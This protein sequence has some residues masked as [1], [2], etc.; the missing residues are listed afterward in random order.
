MSFSSKKM[1]LKE[2]E[3]GSNL[4]GF[5]ERL[6]Q[7]ENLTRKESEECMDIV[8]KGRADSNQVAALLVLLRAKGET[9]EEVEGIVRT[10]R[11]HMTQVSTSMTDSLLDI[12][13]TGG[14]GA[15]TVNLSTT[16]A[17]LAAACGARVA[18]HGNRSVSS[19]A[20]SADVLEVLGV[21]MLDP[22]H[23]ESCIKDAGIAFMFAPKFHPAMKHVVPVRR[24]LGVRTI[25]N[26]LGPL[27]NP[28]RASRLFLGVFSPHLLDIYGRVLMG[29]GN[30]EHALVVH[31]CGLDE[32][33]PIG[34]AEAVEIRKGHEMKR[35]RIDPIAMG[36]P[37]CTVADLRGGSKEVNAR[38]IRGVLAG[39]DGAT[40]PIADTIALNAGAGLYVAGLSSSIEEG[41]KKAQATLRAGDGLEKLSAWSRTACALEQKGRS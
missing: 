29:L 10:M 14:D 9:P 24:S 35:I 22:E 41:Y 26:I 17:I 38:I 8:A 30:V 16:A 6:V 37:R 31:C 15:H 12:V 3:K 21:P 28:A 19:K 7:G 36:I 2:E 25:F 11:A 27:L 32:L 34:V 23:I 13:G 1:K 5:L 40:G 33:A 39:G 20:G 4:K 18:K